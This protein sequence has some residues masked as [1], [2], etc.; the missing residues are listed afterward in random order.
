[1]AVGVFSSSALI[2][3]LSGGVTNITRAL[4][5][6]SGQAQ[7][8]AANSIDRIFARRISEATAELTSNRSSPE[9]DKLLLN[10]ANIINR[11]ERVTNSIAVVNKALGQM[12]FLKNHVTFLREQLTGLE[13]GTLSASDV[14]VE[15][16]N[17]LRKINNRELRQ[18]ILAKYL[19]L[20]Y[21]SQWKILIL[22]R[23]TSKIHC[24]QGILYRVEN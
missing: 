19:D 2:G 22:M 21:L 11:R 3:A 14:A 6:Q 20:L 16:D 7:N 1:M 15:W 24:H 8:T 17:K 23:P 12:S 18:K 5:G 9:T 10:R 13:A 4:V